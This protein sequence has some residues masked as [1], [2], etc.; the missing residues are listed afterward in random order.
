MYLSLTLR[1]RD[2]ID[3]SFAEAL[4]AKKALYFD[5]FFKMCVDEF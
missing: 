2:A 5:V 1:S 4:N 3:K